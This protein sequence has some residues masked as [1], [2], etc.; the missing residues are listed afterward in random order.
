MTTAKKDS[1]KSGIKEYKRQSPAKLTEE[2]IDAVS[3]EIFN[4][5]HGDLM[6]SVCKE[7]YQT[8]ESSVLC[9]MFK[10]MGEYLDAPSGKSNSDDLQ[11]ETSLSSKK[12]GLTKSSTTTN[13]SQFRHEMKSKSK[14]YKSG[15]SSYPAVNKVTKIFS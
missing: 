8:K 13:K 9:L 15:K 7:Y 10:H 3:T 2:T 5:D 6:D 12:D 4:F 11:H 1:S 14:L